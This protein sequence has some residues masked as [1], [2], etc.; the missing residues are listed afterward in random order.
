MR[1][2]IDE[3]LFCL[4]RDQGYE[5]HLS[6]SLLPTN[7]RYLITT[8]RW[9]NVLFQVQKI[10][11]M[12]TP[13]NEYEARVPAAVIRAVVQRAQDKPDP[14]FLMADANKTYSVSFTF[15]ASAVALETIAIP[16]T[17][18]ASFLKVI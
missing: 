18:N 15:T 11:S 14:M 2:F 4:E 9:C 6:S 12:Y 5:K 10:L 3:L 17:L 16:E 7:S 13:A 1:I 8:L